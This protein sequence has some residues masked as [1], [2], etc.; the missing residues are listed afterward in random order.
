[1]VKMKDSYA[2]RTKELARKKL[3][4][5]V[6]KH[7]SQ[8]ER[9]GLKVLTMLGHEPHELEQIWD[10]LGV[11]RDQIY[12]IEGFPKAYNLLQQNNA[13]GTNLLPR[14]EVNDFVNGEG[15]D[16]TFDII[17]LDYQGPVNRTKQ[18]TLRRIGYNGNLS[19]KSVLA[20]WFL[21]RH[22]K[23][24]ATM[25]REA[26][27]DA[28]IIQEYNLAS[29]MIESNNP[30]SAKEGARLMDDIQRRLK[31]IKEDK[32][33]EYITNL[34]IDSIKG[35]KSYLEIHPLVKQ[36]GI[37]EGYLNFIK[38]NPD[39]QK[40]NRRYVQGLEGNLS[41]L[42]EDPF[43]NPQV[44]EEI[45][46][47]R[48]SGDFNLDLN[49]HLLEDYHSNALE[50]VHQKIKDRVAGFMKNKYGI[51]DETI[52]SSLSVEIFN[53]YME[54]YLHENNERY[55]YHSDRGSPMFL[56]LNLFQKKGIPK[57]RWKITKDGKIEIPK[58]SLDSK[59]AKK[60]LIR[61]NNASFFSI[62]NQYEVPDRET[63][64]SPE[65]E[66]KIPEI[67]TIPFSKENVYM[68]LKEGKTDSEVLELIPEVN[69]KSIPR[70][71][72]HVTMDQK[73]IQKG[74]KKKRSQ[75]EEEVLTPEIKEESKE[76]N[77]SNLTKEEAIEFLQAGFTPEEIM[78]D[79]P[80][81]FT[82]R[83]LGAFQ[84]RYVTRGKEEIA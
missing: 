78:N 32:R 4:G 13:Y 20:T 30:W 43:F 79:F 24:K 22:E 31:I 38:E 6:E 39:F 82:K 56:D 58:S 25:L 63:L 75:L 8:S 52:I 33:S 72:A 71:R 21:G 48:K 59:K 81:S 62:M 68:L 51:R 80:G 50:Y 64:V 1:M 69:P 3:K 57:M 29:Q 65:P 10:P 35:G 47:R 16:Q 73:G 37:E 53:S 7:Y 34:V 14:Q 41:E 2:F 70:Y 11:P 66:V 40:R 54:N 45:I 19:D 18:D 77:L 55:F 49:S 76:L 67:Q 27:T 17:N 9:K 60:D 42:K 28:D 5:F 83:Q 46:Q 84:A 61:R 26:R 44:L 74:R 12:V 36:L 15:A 23:P